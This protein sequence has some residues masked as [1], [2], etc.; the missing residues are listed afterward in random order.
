M[1]EP[2]KV[3]FVTL[4]AFAAGSATESRKRRL[5]DEA[6]LNLDGNAPGVDSSATGAGGGNGIFGKTGDG[7]KPEPRKTTV[8]LN[9]SLCEPSD[10]SSAEF[11]Y[12]ELMQNLQVRNDLFYVYAGGDL[13]LELI[14]LA[15]EVGTC[16]RLR[17]G[18][19][20]LSF[21]GLA[22]WQ[23]TSHGLYTKTPGCHSF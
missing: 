5:S 3:Q 20:T 18:K 17:G 13:G 2:R 21:H 6:D 9:L 4:S 8:R 14:L 22:W 1:A 23:M 19:C 15:R 12:S 10:Q 7:D 11:N 16:H